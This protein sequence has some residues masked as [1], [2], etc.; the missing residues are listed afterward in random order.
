MLW[1][2]ALDPLGCVGMLKSSIAGKHIMDY[3]D[4][5]QYIPLFA[6]MFKLASSD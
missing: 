3:F 5:T 2:S 6:W 4:I 1:S